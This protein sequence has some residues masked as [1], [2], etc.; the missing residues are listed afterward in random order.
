LDC[1]V[2]SHED[3]E[4]TFAIYDMLDGKL[5]W[6]PLLGPQEEECV[7]DEGGKHF[8]GLF[9]GITGPPFTSSPK[10]RNSSLTGWRAR[11][12]HTLH[13][14]CNLTLEE[15]KIE[16]KKA[17]SGSASQAEVK[18]YPI[19]KPEHGPAIVTMRLDRRRLAHDAHNQRSFASR[20]WIQ[21]VVGYNE[22]YE[23]KEAQ[24]LIDNIGIPPDTAVI[25]AIYANCPVNDVYHNVKLWDCHDAHSLG[26]HLADETV[27]HHHS[28]V[29]GSKGAAKID[30][31]DSARSKESK[32]S[33]ISSVS[34]TSRQLSEEEY[35]DE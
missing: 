33:D 9:L 2:E 6:K 16:E 18:T 13:M 3:V 8:K 1:R 5:P 25:P 20:L 24:V 12:G 19:K 22:Q 17:E 10:V 31:V 28:Y 26:M 35:G 30:G 23:D 15:R 7:E 11:D 14:G 29:R 27:G 34:K 21:R 4:W 32:E